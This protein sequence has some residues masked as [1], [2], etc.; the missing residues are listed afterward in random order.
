MYGLYKFSSFDSNGE[1]GSTSGD[2]ERD[3]DEPLAMFDHARLETACHPRV[4]AAG[5]ISENVDTIRA[6]HVE[7]PEADF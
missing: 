7:S 1:N 4:E 5:T 6:V 2:D 3:G